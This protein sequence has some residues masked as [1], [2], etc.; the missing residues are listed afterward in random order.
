M[1]S[2]TY[3]L[4]YSPTR[5]I[6][7]QIACAGY[8]RTC[9]FHMKVSFRLLRPGGGGVFFD[10]KLYLVAPPTKNRKNKKTDAP[11]LTQVGTQS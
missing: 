11:Y 8:V 2:N 4:A 5:A 9:S 7:T 10:E 6:C 1:F 3:P